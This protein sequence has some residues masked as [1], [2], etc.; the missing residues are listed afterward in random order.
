MSAVTIVV[1][2]GRY[3]TRDL[4]SVSFLGPILEK[5]AL[6]IILANKPVA[7]T[8]S[9][10][11]DIKYSHSFDKKEEPVL[12]NALMARI[13]AQAEDKIATALDKTPYRH[14]EVPDIVTKTGTGAAYFTGSG[15]VSGAASSREI[16]YRPEE[17]KLPLSVDADSSF[18][19]EFEFI[20]STDGEVKKVVPVVSS[21][22]PEVDLMR[23]LKNW[24]FAPLGH[25]EDREESGRA[26]FILVREE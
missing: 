11:R 21:G 22:S 1:L 16:I 18:R 26:R 19:L 7:V 17:P 5:T 4:T 24:R 25:G 23:Y 10:Q 14:K 3:R 9:Y 15:E 13:D 8:T 2:P 6:D 20:V 12:D